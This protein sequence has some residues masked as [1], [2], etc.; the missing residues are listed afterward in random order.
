MLKLT[1]T[2]LIGL[3]GLQII[4]AT[5]WV[6]MHF[7]EQMGQAWQLLSDVVLAL[8]QTMSKGLQMVA[9]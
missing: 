4:S 1:Q 7:P 2:T 9:S 3:L 6:T 8:A 5:L